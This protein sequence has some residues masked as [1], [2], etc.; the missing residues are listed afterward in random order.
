MS[1][2]SLKKKYLTE[3]VDLH[4]TPHMYVRPLVIKTV[5]KFWETGTDVTFITGM[6]DTMKNIVINVL[7][8]YK[9]SYTIGD[10]NQIN[11]GFIKTTI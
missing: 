3:T 4:G 10:F 9:L 8:E 7:N 1:T 6:S 2:K 5:E 11:I